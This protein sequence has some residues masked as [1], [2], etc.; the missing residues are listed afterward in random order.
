M[1]AVTRS[2]SPMFAVFLQG[3]PCPASVPRSR[4]IFAGL[5][6]PSV[7]QTKKIKHRAAAKASKFSALLGTFPV[8]ILTDVRR[9]C[10]IRD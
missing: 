7:K 1:W 4:H 2:P 6:C 9:L 3:L 8:K 5:S 10:D